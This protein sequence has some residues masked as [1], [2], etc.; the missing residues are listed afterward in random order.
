MHHLTTELWRSCPFWT[1]SSKKLSGFIRSIR[2]RETSRDPLLRSCVLMAPVVAIRRKSLEPYTFSDGNLSVPAGATVCVSAYNLMHNPE[3]YPNPDSF[4]PARFLP[5]DA[6][7]QQRRFT[8]ISETFPVWGYGS[9]AWYVARTA[10]M[11]VSCLLTKTIQ[12][13]S[14]SCIV[15]HQDGGVSTTFEI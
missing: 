14:A 6:K 1:A 11:C 2:V 8:E 15:G 7:D 5:D 13:R 4:E 3:T 9:L 10:L 12:S